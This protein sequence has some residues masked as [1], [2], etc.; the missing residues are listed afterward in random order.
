[1]KRFFQI[2]LVALC[3]AGCV[4]LYQ[5]W[6]G[7][8]T[9][10]MAAFIYSGES[11][12]ANLTELSTRL[13]A[14]G[15]RTYLAAESTNLAQN[16]RE[17]AAQGAE[18]IVLELDRAVTERA[19][20]RAAEET[21]VSLLFT[22]TKPADNLLD[23]NDRIWYLGANPENAGELIGQRT[24]EAFRG[25]SIAD[26]N[27]NL[28][29]DCIGV[30]DSSA[31]ARIAL[32]SAL[33]ECEHYGVYTKTCPQN[34]SNTSVSDAEL[35]SLAEQWAGLDRTP[36]VIFCLGIDHARQA[37]EAAELLGWLDGA[38]PVRLAAV[39]DTLADAQALAAYGSFCAIA[40]LDDDDKNDTIQAMCINLLEHRYISY[41]TTLRQS[42]DLNQFSLYYQLA[43]T[44]STGL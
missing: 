28:L 1:M 38:T 17:L 11:A 23:L 39:T 19:L 37:L 14:A 10:P 16:I 26:R 6:T 33:E 25:G 22:G 20:V 27:D 42:P 3:L 15:Y 31:D 21:G 43:E 13:Q 35:P 44:D 18:V 4:Q 5:R 24:A 41:G 30:T 34:A 7:H 36:E 32:L 40:Y 29:L 2:V 8:T 9:P 12:P